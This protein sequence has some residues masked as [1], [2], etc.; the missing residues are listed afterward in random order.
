LRSRQSGTEEQV[1]NLN[2][3]TGSW[4]TPTL[5]FR[6]W[7]DSIEHDDASVGADM[8]FVIWGVRLKEIYLRNV[9]YQL[10]LRVTSLALRFDTRFIPVY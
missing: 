5:R 6:D 2:G 9:I 8:K 7:R 10:G 4:Q 3:A 1:D